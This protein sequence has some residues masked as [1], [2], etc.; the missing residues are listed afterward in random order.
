MGKIVD[1]IKKTL[2]YKKLYLPIVKKRSNSFYDERRELFRKEGFCALKEFVCCMEDVNIPFWLEFGTLLG[3][4]RDGDFIP[5]D[6]DIDIGAHLSDARRIYYALT[7]RGFKLVREFHVVG[8]NGLEQ[9]YEYHG[10]TLDVM[11]FFEYKN[12][13]WCNGVAFPSKWG[14]L[15]QVPVTAHWFKPFGISFMVFKGIRVP[16]PDNVEEHLIE[17]FGNGFRVYDPDF[18][19]DLNKK[20]YP[21]DEKC[22]WGIVHY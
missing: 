8:E 2:V 9:T 19:G 15:V 1:L 5:N 12:Q 4:Y 10:V 16:I 3:A 17:I 7:Q 18:P 6:L 14:K 22:A 13:Y 11:Y 20:K 21:F